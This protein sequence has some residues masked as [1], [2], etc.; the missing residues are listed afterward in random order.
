MRGWRLCHWLEDDL[1]VAVS[2]YDEIA[3][4]YDAWVDGPIEEDPYLREVRSLMGEI[5]GQ[6][7]CDLACGQ[8]R[9]A[10]YMAGQGAHMVGIDL[11]GKLLEI[12]RWHEAEQPLGIE[13]RQADARAL[14]G[15]GDGAFDG[16]I[17]NMALMD[18]AGLDPTLRSVARILRPGGWFAFSILHPCY[19]T[20]RS[21]EMA[22]PE[23]A[24]RFVG[25]YFV[26]GWW[27]SDSRTGPPGKVGAYHRTL[28]SYFNGLIGAGLTLERVCEM[29]ATG[30]LAE[31]WPGWAEVPAVLLAR[32]RK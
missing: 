25:A 21:G 24:G 9:V 31:K 1:Y 16:V 22:T 18:I 28:S 26:E 23:G 7:I 14:S 30:D 17:C 20:A 32:C 15:V 2:A 19:N 12:A 6:R 27:R 3:E 5:A 11:S 8:G 10:R 29:Q 4:W 13:Y